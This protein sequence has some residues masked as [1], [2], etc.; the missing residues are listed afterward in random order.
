[1][2]R[3]AIVD[4]HALV[5]EGIKKIF[6]N[7][8]IMVIAEFSNTNGFLQNIKNLELDVVLLDLSMPD[9]N[10][11]DI[12]REVKK[13]NPKLAILILSIHPEERYALRSFS[14]GAD[15]YL[16]KDSDPE[17]I[18][19]AIKKVT[20][21]KKCF[22]TLVIDQMLSVISGE[23]KTMPH[24]KLSNREFEILRSLGSGQSVKEIGANLYLSTSTVNTYRSRIKEKLSLKKNTEL[25][26]YAI[27]NKLID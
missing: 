14:L 19:A 21:G 24:D 10:G 16:T 6:N 12:I 5:R 15:G 3:I 2:I 17:I 27:T 20:S 9:C 13:R 4:D 22:S 23:K 11:L 8:D 1:M 26:Y 25:I 7:T 18:I